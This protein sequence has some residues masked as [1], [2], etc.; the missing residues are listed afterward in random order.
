QLIQVPGNWS[1]DS[2]TYSN[3]KYGFGTY[4]LKILV[5]PDKGKSY[6]IHISSIK[7]SSEVY[8]NKQL[9]GHS[10]QPAESRDNYTPLNVPY[11][12]YFTL[13]EESELELVIQASNYDN[14]RNAGIV[15]S[16]EFGLESNLRKDLRFSENMVWIACVAYAIHLVYGLVLYL[17][18]NRD[19]RL[20][21]YSLMIACVIFATLWD[22]E[23]LLLTWIP[24]SFEWSIKSM[25]LVMLFGGVLLHQLI[26]D[27]LPLPL[28]NRFSFIYELLC[29]VA[30]LLILLLPLSVTIA[31]ESIYIF[32]T[33]IPCLFTVAVLYK[34]ATKIDS[35]NIFLLLAAVAAFSS[36]IWLVVI[37]TFSID[38]ISYPFDLIIAMIC[39]SAFW[40][41]RFFRL[42]EESHQ[43]AET[44]RQADKHKDDFL[45]TVAHELSNPLNGIINISQSVAERGRD[46]LDHSS[47][48]DLQL[49]VKVGRRMS[50]IL[51]DLLD[52]AR[53]KE[54][55]INLHC[56]NISV[57]SVAASVIDTLR[58]MTEGKPIQ[59][60]NNIPVNFPHVHADENRLNQ[61]LFNLLHNAI[62]FSNV[63]EVSVQAHIADGWA[64][65]AVTDTGIG[66]D[67][68][69]LSTIFE[70]YEQG[71]SNST[72]FKSGFGLGLGICKQLVDM[73][74]GTLTVNSIPNQGS[75]FIFTLQL[76]D[77]EAI[78]DGL[79]DVTTVVSED[80]SIADAPLSS[81][82]YED[83]SNSS[84]VLNRTRLLAVD[85][86]PVNLS[87]LKTIFSDDRYEVVT[88]IN[89]QEALKL[90]ENNQWD[91]II[92]D[93]VMP[94]ISGYELTTRIR[95]RFSI[96]ELPILLLT[97]SNRDKDIELGFLSGANDYVTKPINAT[98]LKARV[99]SLTNLKNSVN[100]RLRMEA[101]LLQAQ[102]KPHFLINT[103]N[104]LS[105]LSWSDKDKMDELIQELTN[106]FRLGIDFQN[107]DQAVP[108]ERELKLIRSYLFIQKERFEDRLQV[109]W[110]IDDHINISIPPLTIQPLVDNA[111]IHGLLMR[112]AG[113]E[114]RIRITDLG[115]SVE[116]C[117]SDNG[118]G[119][120]AD[121]LKHILDR[122]STKRSGIGLL[123]THRRLMQ[124]YGS[125]LTIESSIGVGTSVTFTIAKQQATTLAKR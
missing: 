110:E 23:R 94:I 92:S 85:D 1:L 87:V 54:N 115:H 9:I 3:D 65:I 77:S 75:T 10:G 96:T 28:Q 40:F 83:D 121:T 88:A 67:A 60:V 55:R 108:L 33:F 98:E 53:L 111:V 105:A 106:Y 38:V 56:T 95:E 58:F 76:V 18:G 20:I 11:T 86:D 15:D 52:I 4:R 93:V 46:K 44:L 43:L 72:P 8:L 97:A 91:L 45:A 119:I 116:F 99:K 31:L 49:L 5:D 122:Q 82:S 109:V 16:I 100:E 124:F 101:A 66:I 19:K 26:K 80:S 117:V 61:I 13:E 90:V 36:M 123:N 103:F 37:I 50:Y 41:R 102:I 107:S 113:G 47:T 6:G 84:L 32:L 104:A 63:G 25:Y 39:F 68:A 17:F 48:S 79:T 24:F 70:P 120:D 118:I 42:S 89:G 35:D 7:N 21:Y 29:G 62:K 57:H 71:L 112:N 114:V 34:S 30:A 2:G 12:M 125:G 74:G 22:G 59:L 81:D 27:K 51:N 78:N 69:L 73:H 14:I 64:S